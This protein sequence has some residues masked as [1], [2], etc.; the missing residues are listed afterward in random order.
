MGRFGLARSNL[1]VA[2]PSSSLGA[3]AIGGDHV[4]RGPEGSEVLATP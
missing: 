4:E 1:L 2:S 3:E